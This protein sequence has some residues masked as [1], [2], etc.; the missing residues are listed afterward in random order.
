MSRADAPKLMGE[1]HESPS[2]QTKMIRHYIMT[3]FTSCTPKGPEPTQI[4]MSLPGKAFLH[5]ISP[6]PKHHC[7]HHLTQPPKHPNAWKKAWSRKW[8][9]EQN[10]GLKVNPILE[11]TVFLYIYFWKGLCENIKTI[12]KSWLTDASKSLHVA[13]P[14]SSS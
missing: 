5:S 10:R 14:R 3:A 7:C 1:A 2:I 11:Y 12:P 4:L 13:S 9:W 8:D 6:W